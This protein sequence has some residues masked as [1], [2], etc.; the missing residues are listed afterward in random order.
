MTKLVSSYTASEKQHIEKQ[1][2]EMKWKLERETGDGT[3]N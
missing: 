3:G 2:M 1:K